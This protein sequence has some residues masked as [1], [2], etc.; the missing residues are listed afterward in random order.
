MHF[1]VRIDAK[2][3][4]RILQTWG[5]YTEAKIEQARKKHM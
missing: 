1:K 5:M 2:L 4:A 3:P